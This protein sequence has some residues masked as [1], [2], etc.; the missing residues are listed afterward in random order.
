MAA[1][2][3]IPLA[4]KGVLPRVQ[5]LL[6]P[7]STGSGGWAHPHESSN[8]GIVSLDAI[9]GANLTSARAAGPD[10]STEEELFALPMSPRSPEMKR[11]PFSLL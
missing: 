3:N 9:V 1:D 2:L 6:P 4:A 5:P 10:E 7:V 11:S 8:G